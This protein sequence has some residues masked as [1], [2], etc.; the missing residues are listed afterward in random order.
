M[1]RGE[2][3]NLRFGDIDRDRHLIHVRPE[4]AKS[5]KGRVVP[6]GT[7]LRTLLEWLRVGPNDE[8]LPDNWLVFLHESGGT[9][10]ASG[11]RGN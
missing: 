9:S 10:R 6:I 2:L 5:K 4:I 11:R 1:R 3:L 7:R 8:P